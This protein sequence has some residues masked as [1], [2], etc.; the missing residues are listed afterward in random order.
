[1][2]HANTEAPSG[3]TTDAEEKPARADA[4]P[5]A[6]KPYVHPDPPT[7]SPGY[8]LPEMYDGWTLDGKSSPDPVV[9]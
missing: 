2:L 3:A 8:A 6:D 7:P 4:P 5:V 9:N 1:M